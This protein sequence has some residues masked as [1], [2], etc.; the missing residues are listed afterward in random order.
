MSRITGPPHKIIIC[1]RCFAL[2][3][4]RNLLSTIFLSFLLLFSLY[5]CSNETEEKEK[6]LLNLAAGGQ[7]SLYGD[8]GEKLSGAINNL[9]DSIE[10]V[11]QYT[12]GPEA[13]LRL[14]SGEDCHLAVTTSDLAFY[15]ARAEVV[16]EGET[17]ASFA[18]LA[19]L[20]VL[21]LHVLASNNSK[22]KEWSRLP[23]KKVSLGRGRSRTHQ[24]ASLLLGYLE[25]E[26]ADLHDYYYAE[27]EALRSLSAGTIDAAF[28]A[29]TAPFRDEADP[30]DYKLLSFPPAVLSE[31][32]ASTSYL[33]GCTIPAG[34][35][36]RQDEPAP[37]LGVELLLVITKQT[38][39]MLGEEMINELKEIIAA[40]IKANSLY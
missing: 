7:G 4:N 20:G 39:E 28:V 35:F 40:E 12:A 33:V 25:L 2:P 17:I 6:I 21:P 31:C 27:K 18:P 38:E 23:G 10:I 1:G 36:Y 8:L 13:N 29:D 16:F 22:L 9:S 3:K 11:P 14:L 34:T 32:T 19:T 30:T 5:G 15:A 24:L 37:G 26:P